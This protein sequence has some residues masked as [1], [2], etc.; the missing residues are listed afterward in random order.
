MEYEL[1]DYLVKEGK[2]EDWL[3]E[4]KAQVYPLRK[5]FGFDVLGA[6][7]V[8]GENRFLWILGYGGP[9]KSFAEGD[10]AYYDSEDRRSIVPDPARN[11]AETQTKVIESAL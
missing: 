5:K 11:L 1:R 9:M 8:K 10:R 2:M 4:W 3:K 7:T 6:W